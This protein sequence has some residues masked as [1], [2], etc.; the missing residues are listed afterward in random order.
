MSKFVKVPLPPLVTT[1]DVPRYYY[2]VNTG[3]TEKPVEGF[4]LFKVS[5]SGELINWRLNSFSYEDLLE[6]KDASELEEWFRMRNIFEGKIELDGTIDIFCPYFNEYLDSLNY[7]E[8][9]DSS[10]LND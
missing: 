2:E 6:D 9:S 4:V 7:P 10:G 8:S 3:H 1:P 5:D